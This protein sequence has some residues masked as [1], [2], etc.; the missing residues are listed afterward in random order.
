MPI[1]TLKNQY[2]GINAHLHS[3]WQAT[4]TWNRFHNAYVTHL[5]EVFIAQLLHLGYIAEMED[6]IQV[7]RIEKFWSGSPQSGTSNAYHLD[8]LSTSPTLSVAPVALA[9]ITELEEDLEHQYSA[10]AL[11]HSRSA[12]GTGEIIAWI[13]LLSPSTKGSGS[14]AGVYFVKRRNILEQ[15]SIFVEIDYLHTKPPTFERLAD[16]TRQETGAYPYRIVVIDPR[17]SYHQAKA[18]LYEF[19]VDVPIPDVTVSLSADDTVTMNLDTLYQDM[20]ARG[21]AYHSVDYAQLPM[22]F[23]RYTPADQTR[24]A[25]RML[26]VMEAVRD[27]VD[28]ATIPAPLDVKDVTLEDA[29]EKIQQLQTPPT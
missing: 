8:K 6:S 27:G 17:P 26:A 2:H 4:G 1:H 12:K 14:N 15:G 18:Y 9:N 29:L 21:Y 10:I 5:A 11:R 22:E 13:E 24:I 19:G 3:F 23:E 20:I 28:L 7:R 25:R 16:Y